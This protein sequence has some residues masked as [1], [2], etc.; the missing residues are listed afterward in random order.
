MPLLPVT[1][2]LPEI[3]TKS[4]PL[5]SPK[6][7]PLVM[8]RLSAIIVPL[9]LISPE[10]VMLPV[11]SRLEEELSEPGIPCIPCTPCIPWGPRVL[12]LTVSTEDSS[13]VIDFGSSVLISTLLG[14]LSVIVTLLVLLVILILLAILVRALS[15]FFRKFNIPSKKAC[16]YSTITTSRS[17]L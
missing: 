7:V 10:A 6:I 12:I 5:L 3:R 9:A 15:Y 4:V 2:K 14:L 11:I 16:Y 17:D 8:L 13:T 1:S